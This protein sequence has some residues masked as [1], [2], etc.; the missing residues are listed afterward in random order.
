MHQAELGVYSQKIYYALFFLVKID[1][2]LEA[3]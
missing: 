3:F 1:Q 2:N